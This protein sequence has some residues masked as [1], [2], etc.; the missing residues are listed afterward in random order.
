M[1]ITIYEVIITS[2]CHATEDCRKVIKALKN[3]LPKDVSQNIKPV[4]Q[5]YQGYYGNPIK[6][7]TVTLRGNDAEKFLEY[8]SK[9]LSDTDKSILG[10]TL[11]LRYDE[12]NNKLFIRFDKQAAYRGEHVISDTDD[13]VKI[14]LS[15]KGPHRIDK[16][17]DLLRRYGLV[18]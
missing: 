5:S 18:R 10:I 3:L 1:N 17:R 6:V 13:I 4:I 2:H 7:I 16:V 15:F 14:V 9:R 8:L 11:D 12:R